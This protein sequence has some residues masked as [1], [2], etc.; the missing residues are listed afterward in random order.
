MSMVR[1]I[2]NKCPNC[3]GKREMNSL[4]FLPVASPSSVNGYSTLFVMAFYLFL[5]FI[6]VPGQHMLAI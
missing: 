1:V 2:C 3:Q 6:N 4:V 5:D